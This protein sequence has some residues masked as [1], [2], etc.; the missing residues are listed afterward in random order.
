MVLCTVGHCE[1]SQLN[2][3]PCASSSKVPRF[4]C[5]GSAF[6]C[7]FFQLLKAPLII[8]VLSEVGLF[9]LRSV[10]DARTRQS[11]V[12]AAEGHKPHHPPGPAP[13]LGQ[14]SPPRVQ[15]GPFTPLELL[16]P[17]APQPEVLGLPLPFHT[18]FRTFPGTSSL[19]RW[20][21]LLRET[22]RL[23]TSSNKYDFA[24]HFLRE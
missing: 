21:C 24:S 5:P 20:R 7:P 2:R 10:G 23:P 17:M 1:M 16:L 13:P 9:R 11:S 3:F 4:A 14:Q 6:P 12:S 22:L 15:R 18:E 8:A 19:W